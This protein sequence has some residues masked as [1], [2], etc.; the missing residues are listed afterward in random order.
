MRD[1]KPDVSWLVCGELALRTVGIVS[2][3]FGEFHKL[4]LPSAPAA[5]YAAHKDRG[6]LLRPRAFF[7][8]EV[9]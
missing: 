7:S 8:P 3:P 4:L 5:I 9:S 1:K 6:I 2:L